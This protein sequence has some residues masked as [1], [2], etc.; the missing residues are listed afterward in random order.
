MYIIRNRRPSRASAELLWR[1]CFRHGI[2]EPIQK[3]LEKPKETRP[4]IILKRSAF[5]DSIVSICSNPPETGGIFLGPVETDHIITDFYFDKGANCSGSTYSPD[6]STLA[7][8]MK[9]EWIPKGID[10]KGFVHSHPNAFDR[11]SNG[12]LVYIKRLLNINIK[13][14][15]FFAPVVIPHQFRMNTYVILRDK[16]N[17]PQQPRIIFF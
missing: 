7:K 6:C 15:M 12:D 9:E 10:M 1:P 2:L 17:Q 11:L 4:T 16:P 13:M 3:E 14:S 5:I 8:K